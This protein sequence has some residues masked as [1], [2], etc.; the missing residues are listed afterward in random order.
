MPDR[1]YTLQ[2]QARQQH[3]KDLLLLLASSQPLSRTQLAQRTGLSLT[4]VITLTDGLISHG[5]VRVCAR[6]RLAGTG[7]PPELLELTPGGVCFGALSAHR[8]GLRGAV[9]DLKLNRLAEFH[10]AYPES[11]GLA[12][13]ERAIPEIAAER[14]ADWAAECAAQFPAELRAHMQA[15]ALSMPGALD[16]GGKTFLSVPLHARFIGDLPAALSQRLGLPVPFGNGSDFCAYAE[17]PLYS[18]EKPNFLYVSL[19]HGVGAGVICNGNV[20]QL[21][22]GHS[23]ELGHMTIDYRG[24]PCP[25]GGRGCLERY[26][27]FDAICD[28]MRAHTGTQQ[29]V[30]EIAKRFRNHD[31]AAVAVMSDVAEKLTFGLA[32]LMSVFRM[33]QIILGGGIPQFGAEF[34]EMLRNKWAQCP[35]RGTLRPVQIRYSMLDAYGD[36][37]GVARYTME[38]LWKKTT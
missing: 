19:H 2:A 17:L 33:D 36:L 1:R 7:R 11:W 37:L 30:A 27:G 35:I 13:P 24:R 31:P 21:G 18:D 28:A 25:C 5:W 9:Y 10:C 16:S 4:A 38:Q 29:S 8:S 3:M 14:F 15:M 23:T 20:L 32:N 6:T 26:V 34:L 22:C 12:Q